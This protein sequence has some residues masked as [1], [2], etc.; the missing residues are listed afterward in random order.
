[1]II[2]KDSFLPWNKKS[3]YENTI[4]KKAKGQRIDA[5]ELVLQKILESPLT[6]RRA[7]LSILKKIKPEYS[8]EGL[9]LKL[10]LQ[11]WPPDV[12]NRLIGKDSEAGKY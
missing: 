9:T 12:K 7:N 6:A 4:I 1:M 2:Y 8:L 11:Y 3:E 5:F 10:K